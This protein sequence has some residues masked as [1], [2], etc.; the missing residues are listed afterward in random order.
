MHAAA[1]RIVANLHNKNVRMLSTKSTK[2]TRGVEVPQ[3]SQ[4]NT[5]VGKVAGAV[6]YVPYDKWRWQHLHHHVVSGK[7]VR[8]N[9]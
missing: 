5:W 2:S 1:M 9:S 3:R 4:V 6:V 8:P 7:T